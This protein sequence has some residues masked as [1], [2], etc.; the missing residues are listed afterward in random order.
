LNTKL[1]RVQLSIM[2]FVILIIN[3]LAARMCRSFY[4][5]SIIMKHSNVDFKE[6]K[7]NKDKKLL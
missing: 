4:S 1:S 5:K 3:N 7:A 6:H 2:D